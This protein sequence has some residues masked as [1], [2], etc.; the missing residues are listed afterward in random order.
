VPGYDVRTWIGTAAPKG[1]PEPVLKRLNE[2]MRS[3]LADP[4]VAERLRK[5]G[6]MDVQASSPEEMRSLV[7]GQIA[8]WKKV[9]ADAAIPQQ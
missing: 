7:A 2:A 4:A 6:G 8:R 3:A 5:T 1:L 9:V